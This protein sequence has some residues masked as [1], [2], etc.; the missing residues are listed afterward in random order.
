M[1][2]ARNTGST[3]AFRRY[4]TVS[5]A[6]GWK[7]ATGG[8]F[9]GDGLG[10]VAAYHPSDGSVWVGR[11]NGSLFT[12]Q[13]YGTVSPASGWTFVGGE[14]TG[15]WTADLAAYHP[16]D[17]SLYIARNKGKYFEFRR[18]GTLTPA[19]GWSVVGGDVTRDGVSDL[20]LY[21]PSNG[22]VWVAPTLFWLQAPPAGRLRRDPGSPHECMFVY[23]LGRP[24][25]MHPRSGFGSVRCK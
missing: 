15:D 22:S 24:P 6:A 21:K 1:W 18:H 23:C 2:V 20:V 12:F 10:D 19:A 17:G 9:T 13:R 11:N 25:A 5:P 8:D 14:F 7:L 3:F 4:A 16:S